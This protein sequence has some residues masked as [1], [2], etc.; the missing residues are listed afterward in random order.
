MTGILHNSTISS[1]HSEFNVKTPIFSVL[2]L[3]F[4]G[5][6][7]AAFT[8]PYGNSQLPSQYFTATY[9]CLLKT[10]LQFKAA[11]STPYCNSQLPSQH[12]LAIQSCLLNTLLKFTAAFSTP[13]CNFQ[14]PSQHL[15]AIHSCLLNTLLQFKVAF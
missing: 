12:L 2:T 5:G 10:L 4:P 15:T 11:F 9:S 13:Y 6:S 14:L 8:T 7:T 3:T 1:S